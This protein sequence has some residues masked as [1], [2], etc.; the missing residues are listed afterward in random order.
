MKAVE[1]ASLLIVAL[2]LS[3]DLG[4]P[5]VSASELPVL[6][7]AD[8]SDLSP[9]MERRLGE[10]VMRDYRASGVVYDDREATEFL[11]RLGA[12]IVAAMPN[13]SGDFEFFLVKDN[14]LNAFALPGG[15]VGVH[16]GLIAA[17]QNESELASVLAHEIGHVTQRH[18]ARMFGRQRQG[19]LLAMG[20]MALA[21]LAARSNP[22]ASAGIAAAGTGLA[23]Q[24]QLSFSRDAEREADRVGYQ[25]LLA[26]GFDS[27]A[28]V[29]FF[30]RLQQS[31]RQYE[32]NAPVYLRTHP[33][34]TE[35][36]ADIQ[37]RAVP[38]QRLPRSDNLEYQL[39]RAKM[40]VLGDES[41][42]GLKDAVTFFEVD[43]QRWGFTSLAGR[44]YGQA[45]AYK[46]LGRWAEAA[47]ALADAQKAVGRPQPMLERFG[48][49][50][51]LAQILKKPAA[52]GR[53][54]L[55]TLAD[56]ALALR[57]KHE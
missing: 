38:P 57:K 48:I 44:R 1:K 12:R 17:A 16:S 22:Q 33:L 36:I 30:T 47:S 4:S 10:V 50:L 5:S 45:I 39:L 53:D 27:T 49:E 6:G 24:Q 52:A 32:N 46:G 37:N 7:D 56:D 23:A 15:Y 51:R 20:A 26:G 13:A 11:N 35:R 41:T 9:A 2:L 43:N 8:A 42:Q 18:I 55:N 31:T 40:R 54:E 21:V 19:N 25:A 29:G 28:M 14:T 3:T 34:T